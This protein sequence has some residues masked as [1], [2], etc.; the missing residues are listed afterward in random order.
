VYAPE[1]A[2]VTVR[3]SKNN[4]SGIVQTMESAARALIVDDHPIVRDALISSLITLSVFEEVSTCSSFHESLDELERD[5]NYQLLILDLS[6][7]DI[8]GADGMIYIREHYPDVPIIVFSASDSADVI[9]QCF[10]H[11]VHG[12]VSKKY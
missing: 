4:I 9:A 8:A 1:S 12:F 7:T 3:N 10:E 5:A 6:L 2:S 11:G